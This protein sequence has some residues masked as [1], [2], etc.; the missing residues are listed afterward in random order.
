MPPLPVPPGVEPLPPGVEP[1][2]PVPWAGTTFVWDHEVPL[3]LLGAAP[4]YAEPSGVYQMSLALSPGFFVLWRPRHQLRL[5]TRIGVSF[6]LGND[7]DT[8]TSPRRADLDDI[9]IQIAYA[10]VPFIHGEGAAYAGP[11]AMQDPTLLGRGDVRTWIL[12]TGAVT[13]PASSRSRALG[14]Y[15]QTTVGLGLRQQLPISGGSVFSHVFITLSERWTHFF[16]RSLDSM[17]LSDQ[18]ASP[19]YQ[20]NALHHTIELLFPIY[21]G[22][23]L[24]ALLGLDH[25]IRQSVG[26]TCVQTPSGCI[27]LAP[28]PST[29]TVSGT[30]FGVDLAYSIL[31]ELAVSFGYANAGPT[32]DGVG[33]R[34]NVFYSVDALLFADVVFSFDRL[35]ERLS[36][37]SKAPR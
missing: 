26:P 2:P 10:G 28:S 36:A 34:R 30:R 11:A 32:M 8:T 17:P 35:Y 29:I 1:L 21:R 7:S 37:P 9:P 13:F 4:K 27:M 20:L 5:S 6:F 16:A 31:P 14:L 3:S 33:G 12:P 25:S 23:E 18:L 15:A 19:F 24:H 22:L